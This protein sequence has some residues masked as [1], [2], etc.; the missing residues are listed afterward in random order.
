MSLRGDRSMCLIFWRG[1][2][3]FGVLIFIFR[4]VFFH[5]FFS[6]C[7]AWFTFFS[8][9]CFVGSFWYVLLS[10]VW[11]SWIIFWVF[12]WSCWVVCVVLCL[13]LMYCFCRWGM[14]WV[15]SSVARVSCTR[16]DFL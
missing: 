6:C 14:P 9:C 2:Y 16:R 3:F 10:L 7:F 1:V 12:C 5:I 8:I 11:V 15:T 4:C 13:I